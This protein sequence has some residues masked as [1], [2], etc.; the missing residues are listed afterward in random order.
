[1]M[2]VAYLFIERR[3]GRPV[4]DIPYVS[5]K[6][7]DSARQ[8]LKRVPLQEIADFLDYAIVEARKT[9]FDMQT[10]GAVKQYLNR[11]LETRDQRARTKA[12]KAAHDEREKETAS[13]MDYDRFR[14]AAADELF[15]SLPSDQQTHIEDIARSIAPPA[16]RG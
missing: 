14:R 6:E 5:S 10:L 4:K 11:Y 16:V 9:Q 8:L 7:V 2:K 1:P 15:A 12:A 13:R 3:T